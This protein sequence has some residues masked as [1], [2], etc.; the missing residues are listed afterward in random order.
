LLVREPTG[1]ARAAAVDEPGLLLVEVDRERGAVASRPLRGVFARGDAWYATRDLFR[2]DADGDFWLVDHVDDVIRTAGGPVPAIAIEDVVGTLDFVELAV[3]YGV[4]VRRGGLDLPAVALTLRRGRE[5]DVAALAER[6]DR[7]LPPASRP[8][9][10]RV[11]DRLP[12]TAGH[13]PLKQPLRA[14]GL[15]TAVGRTLVREPGSDSFRPSSEASAEL[16]AALAPSRR[17]ARRA[18]PSR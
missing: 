7:E 6:I 1:F 18:R 15:R 17:K 3:A 12:L 14:E 2:R 4:A 13:R 10:V 5:L 8:V 9:V 11:L 16:L